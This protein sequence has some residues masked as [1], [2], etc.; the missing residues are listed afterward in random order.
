MSPLRCR[1]VTGEAQP[2]MR[3]ASRKNV[4]SYRWVLTLLAPCGGS[5]APVRSFPTPECPQQFREKKLS[6]IAN[7]LKSV[8]FW[9]NIIYQMI[10]LQLHGFWAVLYV[11]QEMVPSSQQP[12]EAV[13]HPFLAVGG[14]MKAPRIPVRKHVTPLNLAGHIP[15]AGGG[16]TLLFPFGHT[17][18]IGPTDRKKNRTT[19]GKQL[20]GAS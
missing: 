9:R 14:L 6:V 3:T 8:E 13:G 12:P 1:P 17:Q 11:C 5:C 18:L 15:V 19:A 10:Q 16:H 20:S 4:V 7:F 2:C